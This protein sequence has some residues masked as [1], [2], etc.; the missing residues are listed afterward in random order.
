MSLRARTAPLFPVSGTTLRVQCKARWSNSKCF[1]CVLPRFVTAKLFVFSL[2]RVNQSPPKRYYTSPATLLTPRVGAT[3][4]IMYSKVTFQSSV[5]SR[6][7]H[8]NLKSLPSFLLPRKF[9]VL[10]SLLRRIAQFAL[11]LGA[12][13]PRGPLDVADKVILLAVLEEVD[14]MRQGVVDFL[15]GSLQLLFLERVELGLGELAVDRGIVEREEHLLDTAHVGRP[16]FAEATSDEAAAGVNAREHV[17][18]P[19]LTVGV[20]VG[21]HVVN[22]SV[23]GQ[24][25]G[26]ALD[27]SVVLGELVES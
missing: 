19:T 27:G 22:G 1:P 9:P 26:L 21:R 13:P 8:S 2:I 15:L 25:D 4:R 17:V 10:T 3:K 12:R 7:P 23:D 20:R 6:N 14:P 16:V 18:R 11:R 24:V 5:I